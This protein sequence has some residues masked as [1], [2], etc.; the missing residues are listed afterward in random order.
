MRWL[1]RKLRRKP[2]SAYSEAVKG[3]F[4]LAAQLDAWETGLQLEQL[5]PAELHLTR[6]IEP[7]NSVRYDLQICAFRGDRE[8]YASSGLRISLADAVRAA[9]TKFARERGRVP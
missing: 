6:T 4:A 9:L 7:D 2:R 3:W 5:T 8:I 1:L